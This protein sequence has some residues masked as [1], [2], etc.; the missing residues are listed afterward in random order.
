MVSVSACKPT[1]AEIDAARQ[2]RG[3][4]DSHVKI[5]VESARYVYAP[6]GS[7]CARPELWRAE[8]WAWLRCHDGKN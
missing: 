8:H 4:H 1:E 3:S 5:L 2:W 6:R 7:I